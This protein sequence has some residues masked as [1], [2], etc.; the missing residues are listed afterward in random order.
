MDKY[1]RLVVVGGEELHTRMRERDR[2][3]FFLLI[4][5]VTVAVT[6]HFGSGVF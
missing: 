3:G 2:E 5:T 1:K 6:G 4:V